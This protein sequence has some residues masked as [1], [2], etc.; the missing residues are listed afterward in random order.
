V[1]V[2]AI[3]VT[4]LAPVAGACLATSLPPGQAGWRRV[5][6]GLVGYAFLVRGF[7]ALVGIG[8]TQLDLGTHYDVSEVTTVPVSLTGTVYHFAPGGWRQALWLT[9]VPQL[10]AWPLFTVVAGWLGA[11]IGGLVTD[12]SRESRIIREVASRPS[13]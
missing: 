2:Q 1:L 9:L 12:R 7:V 4:W 3:G 13:E 10:L 5:L 11:K 8:A 6:R